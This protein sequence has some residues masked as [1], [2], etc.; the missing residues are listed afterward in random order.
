MRTETRERGLAADAGEL[1]CDASGSASR[2]AFVAAAPGARR[3]PRRGSGSARA[4]V[5]SRSWP[6]AATTKTTST[7]AAMTCSRAASGA[8]L[9][10]GP[11][12]ELRSPREDLADGREGPGSSATQSPTTGSSARLGLPSQPA[13]HL[14]AYL[15]LIG[16]H[17]ICT[18][19]LD[20]DA[21][22][23]EAVG[24]VAART[25]RPSHRPSRTSRDRAPPHCRKF[26]LSPAGFLISDERIVDSRQ[27]STSG[28]GD[29]GRQIR[30][31]TRARIHTRTGS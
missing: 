19:V 17:V 26:L 24:A 25:R 18:T 1:R 13:R 20:R 3:S 8:G 31:C 22:G 30:A 28:R 14:R 16:K 7:F 29:H 15:A 6:R 5:R 9:V 27:F 2:S 12:R 10:C 23:N 11:A 4:G 21:A